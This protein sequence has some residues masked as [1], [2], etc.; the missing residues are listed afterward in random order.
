VEGQLRQIIYFSTAA[1]NQD[2]AVIDD[3]AAVSWRHNQA[4]HDSGLL[5][6]AG[7]RYLRVVEGVARILTAT[8]DRIRRDRRHVGVTVLVDRTI[9]KRSF[10]SWSVAFDGEPAFGNFATLADLIAMMRK[11]SSARAMRG[12]LDSLARLFVLN[13]LP[14]TPSPWT[15]ASNYREKSTL[16]RGH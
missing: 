16:D 13:P 4:D 15:L 10:A 11:Q 3:I 9:Q 6:A 7:H 14:T 1:D 12:Q 5:V 8:R 2:A